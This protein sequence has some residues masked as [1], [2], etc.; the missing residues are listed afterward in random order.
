MAYTLKAPP[1]EPRPAPSAAPSGRASGHRAL[2][3]KNRV[4]G[5]PRFSNKTRPGHRPQPKQP[6]RETAPYRYEIA[7]GVQV[8]PNLY[9]FAFNNPAN[10]I[11]Y[12][13]NAV[14]TVALT[15]WT[16]GKAATNAIIAAL[17]CYQAHKCN[18]RAYAGIK[19]AEKMFAELGNPAGAA[20]WLRNAKPGSE[21]AEL[22][23]DCGKY[24]TLTA[25]WV[26][27]GVVIK[28]GIKLNS[29][30]YGT[31]TGK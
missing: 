4:W 12:L 2:H 24:A 26:I 17:S 1:R 23:A 15:T 14:I 31:G 30:G 25:K 28:Y 6:R 22:W 7:P 11:D 18:E 9:A 16:V 29:G 19:N 3:P 8:G 13:G 27:C 10:N 21:C 20:M 5:S